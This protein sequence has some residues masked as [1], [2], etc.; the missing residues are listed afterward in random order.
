MKRLTLYR[1][2]RTE[3]DSPSGR[4]FDRPLTAQG[5]ADAAR[6]GEEV[7]ALSL[8]FDRVLVSP[9]RRAAETA[10]AAGLPDP[11][12]DDRIYNAPVD[13][14]MAIAEAAGDRIGSLILVGHNPGLEQLASRLL[15]EAIDMP[16]GSLIEIELPGD[17]WA[18]AVQAAGRTIR[19]LKPAELS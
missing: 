6:M 16:A 7:R 19:F 1:H 2:A 3:R 15:G 10:A 17:E 18:D 11:Q 4:D 9:A 14:L 5:R 8:R 12:V 13:Q